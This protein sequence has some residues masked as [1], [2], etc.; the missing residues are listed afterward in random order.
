MSGGVKDP[1]AGPGFFWELPL[2]VALER[3]TDLSNSNN[4]NK[5]RD[6]DAG[7][8]SACVSSFRGFFRVTPSSVWPDSR[9]P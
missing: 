8:V 6:L 7:A 3:H 9:A 1:F 5:S 4:K 2:G